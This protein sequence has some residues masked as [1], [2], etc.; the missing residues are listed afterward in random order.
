MFTR[1]IIGATLLPLSVLFTL[2]FVS[3]SELNEKIG[4]KDDNI[5]E[6]FLENVVESKTGLDVDFTPSTPED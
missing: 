6:E 5:A 4:L 1:S 3:C 2:S